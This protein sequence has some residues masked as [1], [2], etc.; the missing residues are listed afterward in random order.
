MIQAEAATLLLLLLLLRAFLQSRECTFLQRQP[1]AAT[2]NAAHNHS[3]LSQHAVLPR[4][5]GARCQFQC[6]DSSPALGSWRLWA[7]LI[8]NFS[9]LRPGA[10]LASAAVANS[11]VWRGRR[12][13]RFPHCCSDPGRSQQGY[14]PSCFELTFWDVAGPSPGSL[15]WSAC[16][17]RLAL[18]HF[19]S[20]RTWP[21]AVPAIYRSMNRFH[22]MR[23]FNGPVQ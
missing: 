12:R 13:R 20:R 21:S 14:F 19:G 5:S 2:T 17:S 22:G 10:K 3:P 9:S 18:D 7:Q 6:S 15:L 1:P 4:W 8:P 11:L 23:P 16:P